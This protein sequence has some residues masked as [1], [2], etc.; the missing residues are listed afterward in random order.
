VEVQQIMANEKM[1][2][3]PWRWEDG[4]VVQSMKKGWWVLLDEV[5][6]AEPQIL[7]RLNSVLEHEPSLVLTENDNSVIGHG[8]TPV[9]TDFRIFGTMNPA[10]YA[11][12]SGVWA[13]T[14]VRRRGDRA[15]PRPGEEQLLAMLRRLVFGEQPASDVN[16]RHVG[17]RQEP[18]YPQLG[19]MPKVEAYLEARGAVPRR[20]GARG[21]ADGRRTGPHRR[22]RANACVH[23][24]RRVERAGVPRQ[25]ARRRPDANA[26][27]RSLGAT[28]SPASPTRRIRNWW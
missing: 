16:G 1:A 5:N 22:R 23:T 13:A 25:P 11:G 20:A 6:L 19:R 10:E 3:H 2:S 17:V 7:E 18:V 28:I 26:F 21:G 15:G 12:R 24:P 14:R 8:G 9:H 27:R 4:L